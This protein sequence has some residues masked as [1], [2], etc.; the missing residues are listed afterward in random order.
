MSAADEIPMEGARRGV[1]VCIDVVHGGT[2]QPP[3]VHP[4]CGHAGQDIGLVLFA[5]WCAP[6]GGTAVGCGHWPVCGACL[7]PAT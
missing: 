1:H 2:F 4:V 5:G 6:R 3:V 7:R